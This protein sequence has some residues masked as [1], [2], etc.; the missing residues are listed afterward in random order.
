MEGDGQPLSSDRR[1]LATTE[2]VHVVV[3]IDPCPGIGPLDQECLRLVVHGARRADVVAPSA[4]AVLADDFL[5]SGFHI[6]NSLH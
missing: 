2:L 5:Y 1:T 4:D 3:R 6:R